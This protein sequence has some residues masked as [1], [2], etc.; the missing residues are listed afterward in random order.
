MI[1]KSQAADWLGW[2]ARHRINGT[3]FCPRLYYFKHGSCILSILLY[4]QVITS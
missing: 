1:I 4:F 2:M 3:R